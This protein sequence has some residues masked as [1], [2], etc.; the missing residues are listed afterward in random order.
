MKSSVLYAGYGRSRLTPDEP[1]GLA[2]YAHPNRIFK[3]I[4]DD[5]YSSC[6]AFKDSDGNMALIFTLDLHSLSGNSIGPMKKAVSEAVGVDPNNIIFNVTH[7]HAAPCAPV[8][9][10]DFIIERILPS[11]RNAVADL[12]EC[13]LYAGSKEV[14]GFNFCRRF[15]TKEGK[16]FEYKTRPMIW[17]FETQ[18]DNVIPMIKITREGKK[19]I[20][21]ANFAAHCDTIYGCEDK[22]YTLSA[23]YVGATR[24]YFES[25]CDAY[26]SIQMGACGD[27]NPVDTPYRFYTFPGTDVYGKHLALA[28]IDGAKN[29]KKLDGSKKIKSA[30]TE[31]RA[32]VD[33]S[34]D[35]E[36]ELCQKILDIFESGNKD[37]ALRMVRENG[38]DSIYECNSLTIRKSHGEYHPFELSAISVGDIA[39]AAAPYEMFND[40]GVQIKK[41]SRFE[42]TF[43]C[44]YSNG[45]EGYIPTEYAF[46]HGGYEAYSC[47]YYPNTAEK[48]GDTLVGL[49]D[50]IHE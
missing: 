37:T 49:L 27:L 35:G 14:Y 16:L 8:V 13:E 39:F 47:A 18:A 22:H 19:D 42:H 9:T 23:D 36:A 34:R 44:A 38:Y 46:S 11:A 33:H 10:C 7:N 50:E 48:I 2:G 28:F 6:T 21:L 17:Q 5:V 12:S 25:H 24:T 15:L 40:T 45:H 4:K 30:V 29:L 41:G 32:L 3:E 20:V 1:T 26:L 43:V 31:F